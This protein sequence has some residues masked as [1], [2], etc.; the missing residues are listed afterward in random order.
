MDNK[1]RRIKSI[2]SLT[3]CL[4]IFCVFIV[5]SDWFRA[6]EW[7][8]DK[9]Q[10]QTSRSNLYVTIHSILPARLICAHFIYK[11]S[12][13]SMQSPDRDTS[14]VHNLDRAGTKHW[15]LILISI[16]IH[17][18]TIPVH[19]SHNIC[20]LTF[21]GRTQHAVSSAMG[22]TDDYHTHSRLNHAGEFL[23]FACVC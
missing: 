18:C 7:I 13:S 21:I 19:V 9:H 4:N 12:P 6:S 15:P 14:S 10:R 17:I 1:N 20:A 22:C 23:V 5:F 2:L 16:I 8:I 11:H 3:P